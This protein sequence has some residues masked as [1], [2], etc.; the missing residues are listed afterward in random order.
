VVITPDLA[1]TK[2]DGSSNYTSGG[3][4]CTRSW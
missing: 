3:P 4:I 2:T 1:I